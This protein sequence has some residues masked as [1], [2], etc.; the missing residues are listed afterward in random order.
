M[1]ETLTLNTDESTPELTAEE[2]DSLQVGEKMAEEQGELLAGKY[3]NAEDLEKAYVELQKKLGDKD[4]VSQEGQ[5][6]QEVKDESETEE[7]KAEQTPAVSLIE[8]ASNE[9]Y[10]NG[11]QL[12]PETIEKFKDMSSSDLVNAYLEIQKNNPQANQKEADVTDSQINRIQNSVGGEKE[13]NSLVTWA[14][15]NLA[16]NEINAFDNLVGTGNADAIQLAVTAIKSKYDNANGY[17][18]RMLT[19]K[20]AET[21][22][23]VYKSQA[24]LVKAMSDP[25]YDND[26][27]YRQDVIAKLER[28]DVDF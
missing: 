27:A 10:A 19:G 6:T 9:Y 18:G 5:E 4:G 26:P 28:S 1:A 20:A 12:K 24:Q 11:N 25:R 3:K 21:R 16:E 14:S 15:N 13:Y 8:E 17:E 2:Q 22:G 7:P 23:D